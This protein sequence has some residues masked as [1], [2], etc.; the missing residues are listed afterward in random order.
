MNC[1]F[2][3]CCLT[4]AA[5]WIGTVQLASAQVRDLPAGADY[6]GPTTPTNLTQPSFAVQKA[7]VRARLRLER[8]EP[9]G[10][11]PL[12]VV[13]LLEDDEDP[14]ASDE[15]A[16]TRAGAHP[17]SHHENK[18]RPHAPGPVGAPEGFSAR[19]PP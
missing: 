13:E 5:F 1:R 4:F 3:F 18:P 16:V 2:L 6:E 11:F 12:G 9:P 15:A 10:D 17:V 7:Q 19:Y 8:M 14:E